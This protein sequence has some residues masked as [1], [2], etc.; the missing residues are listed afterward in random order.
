MLTR[1]S[2]SHLVLGASFILLSACS[3]GPS[4]SLVRGHIILGHEVSAFKECKAK[5]DAW[6]Y[7][8]EMQL[9]TLQTAY[10]NLTVEPYQEVFAELEGVKQPA[11]DCELCQAYSSGFKV[12]AVKK[13]RAAQADD[14][15]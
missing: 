14:C 13:V 8:D 2:W 12:T 15:Q 10:D 3:S 9:N 7:G 6:L 4:S 11:A 1:F 5:D